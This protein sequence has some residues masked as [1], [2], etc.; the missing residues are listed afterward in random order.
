ML[1]AVS[2]RQ[3]TA[4]VQAGLLVSNHHQTWTVWASCTGH[5][6]GAGLAH[7]A[8]PATRRTRYGGQRAAAVRWRLRRLR[9]V[10]RLQGRAHL[11]GK[12]LHGLAIPLRCAAPLRC[13][14]R[15]KHACLPTNAPST[16]VV[17]FLCGKYYLWEAPKAAADQKHAAEMMAKVSRPHPHNSTRSVSNSGRWSPLVAPVFRGQGESRQS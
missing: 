9:P 5:H 10:A 1:L 13:P 11:R 6:D 17:V 8:N 15:S 4:T 7:L 2:G 14:R 16:G 3:R 12:I